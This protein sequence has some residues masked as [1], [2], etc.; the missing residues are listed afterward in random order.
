MSGLS[1]SQR[2]FSPARC[3]CCRSGRARF[4]FC[5]SGTG[6]L[7]IHVPIVNKDVPKCD[8][9]SETKG[10]KRSK[11]NREV[12]RKIKKK[13]VNI[14]K[15]MKRIKTKL[16]VTAAA[17]VLAACQVANAALTVTGSV[18]GAPTGV[19]KVHFDDLTLGV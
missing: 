8:R 16:A 6:P 7:R 14:R 2:Q 3:C 15:I 4:A 18:G 5:A 12:S 10:V 9:P 13:P 11:L 1:P 19:N 17:C